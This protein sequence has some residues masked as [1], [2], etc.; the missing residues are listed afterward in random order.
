MRK[1][2]MHF[3]NRFTSLSI[4][5]ARTCCTYSREKLAPVCVHYTYI[6]ISRIPEERFIIISQE[7]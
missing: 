3:A 5:V 2:E 7:A 4:L 1:R 6:N